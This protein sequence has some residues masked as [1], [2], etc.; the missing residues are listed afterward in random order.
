MEGVTQTWKITR[1]DVLPEL[2]T[3]T[4]VVNM[5]E[6]ALVTDASALGGHR[7]VSIGQTLLSLPNPDNYIPLESLTREQTL[8]WVQ[9]ILGTPRF[10]ELEANGAQYAIAIINTQTQ[11]ITNLNWIES[12]E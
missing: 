12:I 1:I 10:Q 11:T 8:A 9:E 4:N 3:L 7:H 6:W 2:G 5:V